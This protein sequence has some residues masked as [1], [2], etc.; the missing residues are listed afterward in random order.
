M[1][2]NVS[3]QQ[4]SLFAA[5]LAIALVTPAR[6]QS[7]PQEVRWVACYL[8]TAGGDGTAISFPP[9]ESTLGENFS[10]PP[11][12]KLYDADLPAA[13]GYVS[14]R[15][16]W[17]PKTVEGAEA[18]YVKSG[19]RMVKRLDWPKGF[20]SD[21]EPAKPKTQTA[22]P[23]KPNPPSTPAS[24]GH[25]EVKTD[26]SA[27]DAAKAWDDQVRKALAAEARKKVETAAKVAQADAETKR[28]IAEFMANRRRQGSAQ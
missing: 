19:Y 27:A 5:A 1:S 26:T 18:W 11:D 3:K 7:D 23:P 22:P 9:R 17:E 20:W 16:T 12:N 15:C 6:A 2:R 10:H 8:F 14:A 25:I 28:K 13:N 21:D 4:V 24:A